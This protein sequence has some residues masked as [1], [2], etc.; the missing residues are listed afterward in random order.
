MKRYFL[1][2][3]AQTQWNG[4]N[5]LQGCSDLPLSPLGVQQA[6]RLGTYF[7]TRQ[8]TEIFTSHLQR[9][10]QTAQAIVAGN[11]HRLAPSI[12]PELREM[13]LGCWEGLT[14]EEIDARYDGA[15]QQWASRPSTVRIANAEP[16]EAFRARVR[17]V[18]HQLLAVRLE[19]DYA[20]VT[21]GGVIA[22]ILAELLGADYDAMLRRVRLDNAGITALELPSGGGHPYVLW[23]N[24]TQHLA[25]LASA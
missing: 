24:D 9:S 13:H 18:W 6:E 19:G 7:A 20:I 25:G 23:M 12:E 10:Q 17:D 8:L 3:H 15:Y 4:E 22:A 21:H 5:R 14:P 11:G 16:H 2:R 1:I